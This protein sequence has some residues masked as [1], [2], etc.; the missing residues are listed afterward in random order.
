MD[1]IKKIIYKG[2]N[3]ESITYKRCKEPWKKR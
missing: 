1:S 2:L 3:D